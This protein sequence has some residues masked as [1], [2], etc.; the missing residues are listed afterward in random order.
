MPAAGVAI[1]PN[2]N[3]N[4]TPSLT[5]VPSTP[6]RVSASIAVAMM[7]VIEWPMYLLVAKVAV[8]LEFRNAC[9]PTDALAYEANRIEADQDF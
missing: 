3:S 4:S 1:G 5:V 6:S 8:P 7:E 2:G 9:K